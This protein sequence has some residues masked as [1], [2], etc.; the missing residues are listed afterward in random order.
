MLVMES[1]G[2]TIYDFEL[3]FSGSYVCYYFYIK[4]NSDEVVTYVKINLEFVMHAIYGTST[5]YT[6]NTYWTGT[7]N[8]GETTSDYVIIETSYLFTKTVDGSSTSY[9]GLYTDIYLSTIDIMY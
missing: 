7:L 2:L 8:P 4:N 5:T 3:S 9:T 6:T 1:I